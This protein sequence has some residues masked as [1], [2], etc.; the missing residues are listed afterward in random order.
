M[1][2]LGQVLVPRRMDLDSSPLAIQSDTS[3]F[4]KGIDADWVNDGSGVA[5]QGEIKPLQGN[6]LYCS[7]NLPAGINTCVG[8]LFYE[9]ATEGYVIVHNS[10]FQHCIYRLEGL[11][12]N[13]RIVYRFCP[14]SVF[15]TPEINIITGGVYPFATGSN[16][17]KIVGDP[18]TTVVMEIN[19]NPSV[20]TV[21]TIGN[22][23]VT[24]IGQYSILIPQ[25][26]YVD[27]SINCS[28]TGNNMS[29]VSFTKNFTNPYI[30]DDPTDYFSEGRIAIKSLC[31]YLPDGSKQLYKELLLVNKK[32]FNARIVIEDSI[33][34]NSFTTPFFTPLNPC[35]DDCDRIIRVGVPTPMADIKP[36]PIIATPDDAKIQN[37]LLYKMFKFRFKDI[38]AWGQVSEHG[39]IS[40]PLFINLSNCSRDASASPHCAWLETKTP[41][42]EIVK[43]IVEVQACVLKGDTG[44]TDGALLS[45]WKE[46]ATIDLYDQTDPNLN[47]YDRIYKT[48]N[49]E[50]EFFNNGKDIRFKFCNNRECKTIPLSDIRDQN[51]APITSGS[52]AAIGKGLIYGDN[53]N[54][55]D[56]LSEKDKSG[57]KFEL[58]PTVGCTV[59]YSRIKVYAVI[60]N[61][62]R[63]TFGF[64]NNNGFV[65]FMQQPFTVQTNRTG[66][67]GMYDSTSAIV[68]AGVVMRDESITLPNIG[69]GQRFPDGVKGFRGGLAGT[70]YQA[71][72]RQML[73]TPNSL[74]LAGVLGY[75]ANGF[76]DIAPFMFA[77]HYG[78]K[79]VIQEFDLGLVPC[80]KNY[81]RIFGHADTD[82]IENTSTHTLC[83]TSWNA[84]KQSGTVNTG[85]YIKEIYIDTSNGLDYDSLQDDKILVIS[86][87]SYAGGGDLLPRTSA[88][89]GYLYEDSNGKQPIELAELSSQPINGSGSYISSKFTDHNG[90]FFAAFDVQNKYAVSLNGYNKCSANQL[91]GTT[92]F[93]EGIGA[94][95]EYVY[96]KDRFPDYVTD[97]CNRYIVSGTIKECGKNFGV[98][99]INVVLG[100]TKPVQ[101]NALG[102]FKVVAHFNQARGSDLLIF[103]VGASC[104]VLDCNCGAISVSFTVQQPPCLNCSLNIINVGSFNV[105]TVVTKGFEHGSRVPIG[106]EAH[107]WLGRHT[108]IQDMESWFV[109]IPSEQQ[110]GDATYPRIKVTLPLSFS[111]SF[112]RQF[113][114]LTFFYAKNPSYSDF[115]EWS[116][117]KVEFVDSAGNVNSA[118]PSKVKIWYR[119]LN[120]YNRLTGFKSNTNWQI[121]DTDGNSKV[122]DIVEFIQNADGIYLPPGL[123]GNIQYAKDGSYFLVD[124]DKS[125]ED[126][127]D[128]VRFKL[129]RPFSCEIPRPYYEEGF[130]INFC[131]KDGIPRDDNGNV[132]R[133]FFLD[134]FT[135]YMQPR[136]I[137]VVTDVTDTITL[138]DGTIQQKVSQNVQIKV[139]PFNFEHHSPSDTWGDHCFS[140]G[141]VGFKNPY[142][143]KKCDRNQLKLTGEL[144]NANDGAINYLHYFSLA[145]DLLIDEQGWGGINAII[146]K[147]DGQILLICDTATF[148]IAYND[149]RAIVTADGYVKLPINQKFSKPEKDDSF[150]FGCQVKDLNTIRR[151]GPIVMYQ[152]SQKCAIVVHDFSKATDISVGIKSWLTKGIKMS[153]IN[154]DVYFHACFDNR[155]DNKKYILTRFNK[156]INK[157]INE[158]IE[159]SL[160][161]D[162]ETVYFDLAAKS[163]GQFLHFTPEYFGSMYGEAKD[164]QFFSFKNGQAYSHHN[165]VTPATKYLNYFGVQCF[166]VI[167]VVTNIESTQL[168]SYLWSE[169]YCWDQL[170]ILEKIHTEMGQKSAVYEGAWEWGEGFWKAPYL[171]DTENIDQS[172]TNSGATVINGDS[173]YGRWLKGTY[174]PVNKDGTKYDGRFFKL[175]AIISF[176]FAREKSGK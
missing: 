165:A 131:A 36:V 164:T 172:D 26:G 68:T 103:S 15:V 8:Y 171:C 97:L 139:Y 160:D 13:C 52:V 138:T 66:F 156:K 1:Q 48:N 9:E 134:G 101:T 161:D 43:R 81:F 40:E 158:Q 37:E 106:I 168:K 109:D 57:I 132:I 19:G 121:L 129:K 173:L 170:F 33:A 51:P 77:L 116:A 47:W 169:V 174:I 146:I 56:K 167:G 86:D 154:K 157:F 58:V 175:T 120:E 21:G 102:E 96:A 87:L 148:S 115:L 91:L 111:S 176:V 29:I 32:I 45:D 142:E 71:E 79:V 41:C 118:S 126:L 136:Q 133:E 72:S 82:K 53:Q 95:K 153:N 17:G 114:Y 60:H 107:D 38:N 137:P 127:K 31:K 14:P 166:P 7:V 98:A 44:T 4:M 62:I 18:G 24:G 105:K 93:V 67:G 92:L 113:R 22:I 108:D 28:I 128:G 85:D 141:R 74:S 140:G 163:W 73:W 76:D 49:N 152:D 100:R 80:G 150:A 54:D 27:Y 110:Q 35:C 2:Q 90:Y 159:E 42:P 94:L 144:N 147:N 6:E 104:N 46:Y 84:Y 122:G 11:T 70:G 23:Q 112:I 59:K 12:G 78:E 99:G 135:S 149:D 123:F 143:G 162:N 5:S 119:G 75:G 145:D 64:N 30:T 61:S 130:T 83:T 69:Y 117:D 34:T 65:W 125:L 55:Y 25:S 151:N 88:R 50:F 3:F 10:N 20:L 16:T 155:G 89:T 39:K 63:R 124:Y